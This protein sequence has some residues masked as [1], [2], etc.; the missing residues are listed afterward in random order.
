MGVVQI[1]EPKQP[2]Q[3]YAWPGAQPVEKTAVGAT[4]TIYPDVVGMY[5]QVE[6]RGK[7]AWVDVTALHGAGIVPEQP[8]RRLRLH[9]SSQ[10]GLSDASTLAR[11]CDMVL[12]IGAPDR[13]NE[14]LISAVAALVGK[15]A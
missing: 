4:M 2:V 15:G 9:A 11:I 12:P 6:Y 5:R 14:A 3:L 1:V 7:A 10:Q 8:Q 13:S